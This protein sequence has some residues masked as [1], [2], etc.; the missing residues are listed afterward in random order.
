M[1]LNISEYEDDAHGG[2]DADELD[3]TVEDFCDGE[4]YPTL[5]LD[6]NTS[7]DQRQRDIDAFNAPD[8]TH[9]LFL[10]STRAGGMGINLATADTV[11]VHDL[12]FNPHQVSTVP[13]ADCVLSKITWF[14]STTGH[15][16][17]QL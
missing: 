12:D 16:S 1:A 5:R 6:G 4:G 8:S 2:R 13:F 3:R 10:I 17:K 14:L 7:Q 11:I 9:F 15:A